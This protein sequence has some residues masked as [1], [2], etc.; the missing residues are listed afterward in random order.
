MY[1]E[2]QRDNWKCVEHRGVSGRALRLQT[3]RAERK[4]GV[5]QE[6]GGR[7]RGGVSRA[8]AESAEQHRDSGQAR[9]RIRGGRFE[10]RHPGVH[11]L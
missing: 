2:K 1:H 4:D 3:Q 6:G 5:R 10:E 7:Q 11:Q 8:D 9:G